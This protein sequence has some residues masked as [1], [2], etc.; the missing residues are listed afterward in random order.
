MVEQTY[1][2]C[3][4]GNPSSTSVE[5]QSSGR[6]IRHAGAA[7]GKDVVRSALSFR[8]DCCFS[9]FLTGAVVPGS[10][11]GVAYGGR[12]KGQGIL[13]DSPISVFSVFSQ[14]APKQ[15]SFNTSLAGNQ[16]K[17]RLTL[18]IAS[19]SPL[20]KVNSKMGKRLKAQGEGSRGPFTPFTPF[21][22]LSPG[23]RL[24]APTCRPSCSLK[25]KE[26]LSHGPPEQQE[27]QQ[28]GGGCSSSF[29][30]AA[31][32]AAASAA[33]RRSIRKA[34]GGHQESGGGAAGGHQ[35]SGGGERR[36]GIGGRAVPGGPG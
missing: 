21:T 22:R 27:H 31:E 4:K 14:L 5:S 16:N 9:V 23:R 19:K 7:A 6:K 30:S 3:P 11:L 25:A 33:Q 10:Q 34:A 18:L 28:R 15:Q 1:P 36:R 35:Q 13:Q 24:S 2:T 12:S 20:T 29:S 32:G 8:K 26:L 17:D